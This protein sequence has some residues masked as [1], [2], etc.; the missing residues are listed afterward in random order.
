MRVRLAQSCV[1]APALIHAFVDHNLAHSSVF[2]FHA[3]QQNVWERVIHFNRQ[4]ALQSG[5]RGANG[6]RW[7]L[8]SLAR[9]HFAGRFVHLRLRKEDYSLEARQALMGK[10]SGLAKKGDVFVYFKHEDTPEGAL[11]AE[12]LLASLLTNQPRP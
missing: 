8:D 5:S 6:L 7:N 12:A 9:S 2:I 3:A 1:Q 11:N 10:V 4:H